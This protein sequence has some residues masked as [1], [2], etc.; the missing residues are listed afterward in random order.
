MQQIAGKPPTTAAWEIIGAFV[1]MQRESLD[2]SRP[3]LA[4]VSLVSRSSIA[5]LENEFRPV[6]QAALRELLNALMIFDLAATRCVEMAAQPELVL[7]SIEEEERAVPSVATLSHVLSDPF[8][9]CLHRRASFER[10]ASNAAFDR[11]FPGSQDYQY[12]LEWVM[13][14]PRAREVLVN[15]RYDSQLWIGNLHCLGPFVVTQPRMQWLAER[16][17]PAPEF[18]A[19]FRARIPIQ[20]VI[21]HTMEI[22]DLD[23]GEINTM[24]VKYWSAA[25]PPDPFWVIKFVPQ[26]A[27]LDRH[28]VPLP[29]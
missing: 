18:E 2:L 28:Q 24:N 27:N 12:F 3:E 5:K 29:A 6:S 23:T 4:N 17:S 14:D 1:R 26:L 7:R 19:M 9:A 10:L 20:E 22:R 25:F 21:R 16:L 8:P 11:L 13:L 15:W